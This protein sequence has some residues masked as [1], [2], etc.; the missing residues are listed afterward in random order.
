VFDLSSIYLEPHK[1]L[2]ITNLTTDHSPVLVNT[3]HHRCAYIH[4]TL[5]RLV[6][7]STRFRVS[8]YKYVIDRVSTLSIAPFI[9]LLFNLCKDYDHYNLSIPIRVIEFG[10]RRCQMHVLPSIRI[11]HLFNLCCMYV[12]VYT[13]ISPPKDWK[14]YQSIVR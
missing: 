6:S 5:V 12:V 8:D 3:G 13:D 14:G 1:V 9:Y 10:G 7:L 11:G 2:P 4:A